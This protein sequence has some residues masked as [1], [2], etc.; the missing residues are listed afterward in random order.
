[1]Q[2][3]TLGEREGAIRLL[4]QLVADCPGEERYRVTLDATLAAR[5][6][7]LSPELEAASTEELMQEALRLKETNELRNAVRLIKRR[8]WKEAEK[9]LCESLTDRDAQSEK[10]ILLALVRTRGLGEHEAALAPARRAVELSPERQDALYLLEEVCLALEKPEEASEVRQKA[11]ISGKEDPIKR[12][13][14]RKQ[15]HRFIADPKAEPEA[16]EFEPETEEAPRPVVTVSISNATRFG[17][18]RFVGLFLLIL[19]FGGAL[20]LDQLSR[21]PTSVDTAPY[22]GALTILS[23]AEYA[24]GQIVLQVDL[25]EWDDLN[26]DT[27]LLKLHQLMQIAQSQ[28]YRDIFI[29][30]NQNQIL[31]SL[32]DGRVYLTPRRGGARP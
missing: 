2:K 32:R 7:E 23:G 13:E 30:D 28:G 29:H 16:D 6:R 8:Q 24:T 19:V 11:W 22:A 20:L 14:A 26:R 9:A 15:L 4:R 17:R 3:L 21:L 25:T 12:K 27:Q 18:L 5:A 1:M 31:A 10:Q